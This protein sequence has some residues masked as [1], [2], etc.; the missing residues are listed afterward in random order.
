MDELDTKA[1]FTATRQPLALAYSS[2]GRRLHLATPIGLEELNVAD[3]REEASITRRGTPASCAALAR[4]GAFVLFGEKGGRLRGWWDRDGP[5]FRFDGHE[6]PVTCVALSPSGLWALSAGEDQTVRLWRVPERSG[7]QVKGPVRERR[8][9]D[10]RG[11]TRCLALAPDADRAASGH[12]DGSVR[13]W[14]LETG[15]ETARL[16]GHLEAVT[17]LA[18]SANGA[19]LASASVDRTVR[20]WDVARGKSLRRY[21][22]HRGGVE[23]VAFAPDGRH[24]LSA[25][26]D[27]TVRV[28][29]LPR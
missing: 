25:G 27:H 20:L 12:P 9:L 3:R 8:K 11:E 2:D 22:G 24:L 5:S 14:D 26:A 29:R 6:G 10:W 19:R 28:W 13:V 16:S 1:R 23:A 7:G 4:D 17:A 21:T 18:W 15:R